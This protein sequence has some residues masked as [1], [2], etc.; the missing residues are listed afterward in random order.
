MKIY[1]GNPA[2]VKSQQDLMVW[3]YGGKLT[4][5]PFR[6]EKAAANR[7]TYLAAAK[8]LRPL[9]TKTSLRIALKYSTKTIP[10]T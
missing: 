4:P 10:S 1:S 2:V 3:L 7:S 9:S 8:F 6:D 5:G